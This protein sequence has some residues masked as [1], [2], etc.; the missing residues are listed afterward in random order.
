MLRTEVGDRLWRC[1]HFQTA[2]KR[3]IKWAVDGTW[4][5]TLAAVLA[6][7]DADDDIVRTVS[8]DSTVARAHRHVAGARNGERAHSGDQVSLIS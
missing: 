4:A 7:A 5:R 8:S 1:P 3:P 2:H 6:S